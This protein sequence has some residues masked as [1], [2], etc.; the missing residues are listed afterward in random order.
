MS[1][2]LAYTRPA[3]TS[4]ILILLVVAGGEVME[5]P[6]AQRRILNSVEILDPTSGKGWEAGMILNI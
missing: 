5:F 4:G 1:G 3:T 6:Q 2:Q